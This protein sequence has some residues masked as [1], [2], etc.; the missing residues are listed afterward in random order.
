MKA[1]RILAGFV[2]MAMTMGMMS[3]L[4]LADEAENAPEE[5]SVV[6]TTETKEKETKKPEEKKPAETK[7]ADPE[8]EKK[9]DETVKET[10][11]SEPEE[12]KPAETTETEPAQ[13]S[14]KGPA[15]SKEEEPSKP[16]E[17][18]PE[19]SSV[20]TDEKEPEATVAPEHGGKD[21][22]HSV[23][24]KN[25]QS[26]A[27]TI[28]SVSITLD[29]P[30]YI[31]RPDYT[32]EFPK[33]ANYYSESFSNEYYEN[34][35]RWLDVT[36]NAFMERKTA[37]FEVDHEYQVVL[38]LTAKEG[39]CFSNSTT[40][41]VNEKNATVSIDEEGRLRVAYNFPKVQYIMIDSVRVLVA[42][43]TIGTKPDYTP[44]LPTGAHYIMDTYSSGKLRDGVLWT[45]MT[46]N[47]AVDPDNGVFEANHVYRVAIHLK[48]E[49]VAYKFSDNTTAQLN[50]NNVDVEPDT[51]YGIKFSY[52][53]SALSPD[54]N[55]V[56]VTLDPPVIGEKPDYTAVTPTGGHYYIKNYDLNQIHNDVRWRDVTTQAYV[57]PNN[58]VFQGDHQYEVDVF[59]TAIDGYKFTD[60]TTA[61]VNT[62]NANAV[63]TSGGQLCVT[64]RFPTLDL[65]G[66]ESVSITLDAPVVG[67]NP[68]Y[69][70]VFPLGANYYS[71]NVSTE[72]YRNNICWFELASPENI[73]LKPT[74]VFEDGKIYGVIVWLTPKTGFKFANNTKVTLNGKTDLVVSEY[75]KGEI[76]VTYTPKQEIES[77]SITLDAPVIGAKPDYTAVF[78]EG[79]N[80]YSNE[81]NKYDL[82]N[83]I[84]WEDDTA[85]V[86]VNPDSGTF[87]AGHQYSI[88][89]YLTAKDGYAFSSSTTASLNGNNVKCE[90]SSQGQLKIEYTFPKLDGEETD[91]I[92]SVDIKLDAP[93]VGAKPDYEAVFPSGANYYSDSYNE[94]EFRNDICWH[95]IGGKDVDPDS[96]VFEV[97]H[98]YRVVVYL[99]VKAGYYFDSQAT[100]KLNGT[101]ATASIKDGQL[102]I[103]YEFPTL[104]GMNTGDTTT[105]DGNNYLITSSANGTGTVTLTGVSNQRAAVSIPATVVMNGYVYKVTRIGAKAF[106]GDKTIKTLSIG[107]NVAIIDASAF[108]GCSNLTT[109]SGGKGL[110]TIGSSAFAKCSKLKSF[111]I[112]SSVLSKIGTYAFNKDSKLK[113]ISIKYTTK[114]TKSGVKKS[115]KGSKVKTVKVKKSK[116]KK[117]KKYFK[118]SNSG[119]SVKVK[120]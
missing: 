70:A 40:A 83:D 23:P 91:I 48:G 80:Y 53:F 42:E 99:T 56:S 41:T 36:K 43:P 92:S 101:A 61:K 54:I 27:K 82:R 84:R 105:V 39:Y 28:S 73:Y 118:K 33:G 60:N 81:Y 44:L 106:Y 86:N 100:V 38:F 49:T 67:C 103:A 4:V 6:E 111:S 9:P 66:I 46:T 119:R 68:D 21:D 93:V 102:R 115:L 117:Y 63:V 94:D 65:V 110:K 11:P 78:P 116:V 58:D 16:A 62:N 104:E 24:P 113:T 52:T 76:K 25:E 18:E 75:G 30:M 55:S 31:E 19:T 114:L 45:D 7:E 51:Q 64:Y 107:A 8:P 97:G 17:T 96:G 98:Q 20:P 88:L 26:S 95:D 34:Y 112:A 35:I 90:L 47:K 14:E 3:S 1:K 12:K 74:D 120:K 109:V 5:T 72:Y 87:K 69:T 77:V 32:A 10:E 2:A 29:A 37:Y 15:E 71:S 89:I 108:Y 22:T 79:V 85:A 50:Q 59:I 57:D 13:P